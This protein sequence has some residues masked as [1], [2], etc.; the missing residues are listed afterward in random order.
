MIEGHRLLTS[1]LE[2]MYN[3][4]SKEGAGAVEFFGSH[5]EQ[6][7]AYDPEQVVAVQVK[8]YP[9]AYVVDF[10]LSSPEILSSMDTAAW[11]RTIMN[12]GPRPELR[13]VDLEMEHQGDIYFICKFMRLDAVRM[14]I[15]LPGLDRTDKQ[16]ILKRAQL[17]S[18]LLVLDEV[19]REALDG[20]HFV[21][22]AFLA[23]QARRLHLEGGWSR[24]PDTPDEIRE[25]LQQYVID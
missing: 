9:L 17:S 5:R 14:A 7:E 24:L 23:A 19:D 8:T 6:L 13:P 16:R 3:K 4:Y 11:Q 10:L 18:P 12:A 15:E 1:L 20:T 21:A 25:R 22:E 2:D